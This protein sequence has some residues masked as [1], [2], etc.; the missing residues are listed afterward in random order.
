MAIV[1]GSTV[2]NRLID[3]GKGD[4]IVVKE[5]PANGTGLIFYIAIYCPAE[6]A[7]GGIQVA[8]FSA[9]GNDLTTRAYVTLAD[10]VEGLNEYNAPADFTPFEIRA[11]DYIGIYIPA[12]RVDYDETTG[13]GV[14]VKGGDY[15]P[16]T[17]ETFVPVANSTLSLGADG[18][19]LGQ[20]NV[21]DA[22]KDIQNMQI[23]VG[24][25]WKSLDDGKQNIGDVWKSI[26]H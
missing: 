15:I 9:S 22:W 24:D 18:Y 12:D 14:W 4:T 3:Q 11:G 13:D 16:C 23:N 2:I 5:N 25:S 26:L 17:S 7:S 1:V 20:L 6:A 10:A 8:S 19:Q 21:G